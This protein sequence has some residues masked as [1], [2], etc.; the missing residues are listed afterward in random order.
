MFP[1]HLWLISVLPSRYQVLNR[2]FCSS[3]SFTVGL[4]LLVLH[5]D[6]F[7]YVGDIF[8]V[9]VFPFSHL[10]VLNLDLLCKNIRWCTFRMIQRVIRRIVLSYHRFHFIHIGDDVG[11]AMTKTLERRVELCG[12]KHLTVLKLIGIKT[13]IVQSVQ[14]ASIY[15]SPR[16]WV[17]S[18]T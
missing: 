3:R 8:E 14:S 4:R 10:C 13:S 15:F 16:L 18:M 17:H 6:V 7:I 9:E 1:F 2:V 12:S 11:D 5:F